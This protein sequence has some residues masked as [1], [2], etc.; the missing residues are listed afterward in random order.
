[1]IVLSVA[2]QRS[3]L[4]EG[5]IARKPCLF[6]A[7]DKLSS[8]CRCDALQVSEDDGA[9]DSI[10]KEKKRLRAGTIWLLF[11][12][13][14]SMGLQVWPATLR[15]ALS[16]CICANSSPLTCLPFSQSSSKS[17]EAEARRS[18]KQ[19]R[20][21]FVSVMCLLCV[22][23]CVWCY[24]QSGVGLRFFRTHRQIWQQLWLKPNSSTLF[25]AAQLRSG[26]GQECV[27]FLPPRRTPHKHKHTHSHPHTILPITTS[28]LPR[29]PFHLS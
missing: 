2:P 14:N 3:P 7:R 24:T 13:S 22:C 15:N 19:A 8:R 20:A 4:S 6:F 10:Q 12:H 5:S 1:M 26:V 21:S 27:S 28:T 16:W 17:T 25:S 23:M 18:G 29:L 9:L 11:S